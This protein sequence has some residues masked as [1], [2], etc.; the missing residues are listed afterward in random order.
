MAAYLNDTFSGNIVRSFKLDAPDFTFSDTAYFYALRNFQ[1]AGTFEVL[2]LD[3]FTLYV[4]QTGTGNELILGD[5]KLPLLQGR[6]FQIEGQKASLSVTHPGL[7]ILIAGSRTGKSERYLQVCDKDA[8]KKVVKPWGYELWICSQHEQYA[9]KEIFIKQGTKTSLQYH[10][11]K[12]ETNVLMD[13]RI[14]LHYAKDP[15]IPKNQINPQR[16]ISTVE[17]T[18]PTVIDVVPQTI[19]RIEALSDV[20]LCEVSTSHLDDVIRISDDSGRGDGRIAS[21]HGNR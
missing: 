19:H 3:S 10:Q 13:G 21:E 7:R 11:F 2:P 8:I 14:K 16:D 17:L 6:A 12:Q 18:S 5:Q 20:L 9:F 1:A 15:S 4:L